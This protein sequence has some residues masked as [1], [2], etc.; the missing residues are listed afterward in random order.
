MKDELT[1]YNYIEFS[2]KDIIYLCISMKFYSFSIYLDNHQFLREE[3]NFTH[4]Q[5]EEQLSYL[6]G[7]FYQCLEIKHRIISVVV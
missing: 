1:R 6:L 5:P 7:Y 3:C 4:K 2:V